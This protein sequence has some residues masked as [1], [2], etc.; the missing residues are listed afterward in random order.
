MFNDYFHNARIRWINDVS[1]SF[2]PSLFARCP[3]SAL[4]RALLIAQYIRNGLNILPAYNDYFGLVN[5]PVGTGLNTASVWI[6]GI[7][8][9]LSMGKVTDLI[10]RRPALF[11]SAVITLIA[12]VIQTAAQNVAMFVI[13]RI[14]IGF[15][16]SASGL[17]GPVYL[18]ETLPF[19]WRAWGLGIFNDFFY[20]GEY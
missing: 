1:R 8:A 4:S 14:L 15:G 9:G 20:V 19:K 13:G 2:S 3:S 12:V 16:T 18:A 6:G 10:G 5:N 7:L 11:Y 17:C